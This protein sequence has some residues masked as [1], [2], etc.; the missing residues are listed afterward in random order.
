MTPSSVQPSQASLYQSPCT[1]WSHCTCTADRCRHTRLPISATHSC[2]STHYPPLML[3]LKSESALTSSRAPTPYTQNHKRLC[4]SSLGSQRYTT[5]HSRARWAWHTA[6]SLLLQPRL[7][8]PQSELTSLQMDHTVVPVHQG[9]V[10]IQGGTSNRTPH[11]AV[12]RS[13]AKGM[14]LNYIQQSMAWIRREYL[15]VLPR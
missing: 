1:C 9:T 10:Y 11:I 3:A 8:P 6:D 4:S 7:R 15:V 5:R 14:T 13:P 12:S 2:S